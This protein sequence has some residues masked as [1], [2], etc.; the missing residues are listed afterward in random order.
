M[1]YEITDHKTS[2][3][4][5]I[6]NLDN[7][8]TKLLKGHY[9]YEKHIYEF[10]KKTFLFENIK[11]IAPTTFE[12]HINNYISKIKIKKISP[13]GF[14]YSHVSLL[15]HLGCDS[16]EIAERIGDAIQVIEKTY[17]HMFQEKKIIQSMY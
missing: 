1:V 12:N 4:I 16:C 9:N 7:D 2:S 8:L 3:S 14:R 15:I 5:R 13:H 11:Y 6:V 17:Y 10:S